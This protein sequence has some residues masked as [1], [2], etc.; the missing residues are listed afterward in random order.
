M[1]IECPSCK[2][3]GNINDANV[4]AT[5][6]AMICPRCKAHFTAERPVAGA[7]GDAMVDTCPACQY[8]TFSEEKF[9]TCPKCGLV[10]ADHL[11]KQLAARD[12]QKNRLQNQHAARPPQEE[13]LPLPQLSPEQRKKEEEALRKYGLDKTSGGAEPA[14]PEAPRLQDSMPLPIIIVGWVTVIATIFLIIYGISGIMEFAGKLKDAEEALKTG[15]AALSSGGLF[16]NFA[17]FP[18]VLIIYSLAMLFC[19]GQFLLLRHWAL[20]ALETGAWIGIGLAAVMELA[21]I[22]AWCRRASDN[23]SFGYYATGILGGLLMAA[24]W[25][26]PLLL[27]AEYLK[28]EQFDRVSKL[29]R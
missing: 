9:S 5:G 11:R 4:P 13:A 26:V 22:V 2:L 23:A 10:V 7:G 3:S 6:L 21:D 24:L 8:A 16:L 17:L 25:I 27:L 29:F 18:I 14:E 12:A 1:K 19:A 20:T 28:S 15:E